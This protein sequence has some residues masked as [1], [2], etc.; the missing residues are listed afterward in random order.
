MADDRDGEIGV[1]VAVLDADVV[2]GVLAVIVGDEDGVDRVPKSAGMR[3]STVAS[4]EAALYARP[5]CRSLLQ[6]RQRTCSSALVFS[7]AHA[8]HRRLHP[9]LLRGRQRR[10]GAPR[11]RSALPDAD[12]LVIDDSSRTARPT[13]CAARRTSSAGSSSSSNRQGR[14]RGG[15]PRRL[16]AGARPWLRGR[17]PDGCRLS[18]DPSVLPALVRA[19]EE[20]SALAIGSR[21]VPGGSIPEWPLHRRR[22][23]ATATRTRVG[24]STSTSRT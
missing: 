19:I 3:S 22:C 12:I 24:C 4:V 15:V 2:G 17:V 21:Y 14:A 7:G 9:D 6:A 16:R 13:S 18:H 8:S 11:T 1:G 23:R 10:R 5:G 20:G